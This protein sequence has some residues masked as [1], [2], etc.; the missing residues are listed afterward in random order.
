MTIRSLQTLDG[1]AK[2]SRLQTL[3]EVADGATLRRLAAAVAT[4][5]GGAGGLRLKAAWNQAADIVL[6]RDYLLDAELA[7]RLRRIDGV[8]SVKLS[9]IP[10]EQP[11]LARVS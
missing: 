7:E 9:V 1:L 11:R 2:R 8:L 4:E 6:G 3:V 5:H 10:L